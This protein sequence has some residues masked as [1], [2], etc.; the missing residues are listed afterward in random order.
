MQQPV[1]LSC[2]YWEAMFL[3]EPAGRE[4]LEESIANGTAAGYCHRY[5]PP[6]NDGRNRMPGRVA[7]PIPADLCRLLVR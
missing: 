3:D 7:G 4:R 6:C 5:P 2:R 1:C